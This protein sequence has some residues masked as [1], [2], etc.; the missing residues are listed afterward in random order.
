[1]HQG[2]DSGK[3]LPP[4]QLLPQATDSAFVKGGIAVQGLGL[5]H[6]T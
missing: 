2:G 5:R 3:R 6:K 1:M 4:A